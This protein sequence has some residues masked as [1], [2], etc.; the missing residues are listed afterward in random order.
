MLAGLLFSIAG[1]ALMRLR[2]VDGG[3]VVEFSVDGE[4]FVGRDV[5]LARAD[6]SDDSA[7]DMSSSDGACSMQYPCSIQASP[8]RTSI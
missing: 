6:I 5:V 7:A 1:E 2:M 8:S 3:V 4:D